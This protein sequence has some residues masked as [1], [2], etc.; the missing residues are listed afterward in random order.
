MSPPHHRCALRPSQEFR[1]VTRG[2]RSLSALGAAR[3]NLW[4]SLLRPRPSTPLVAAGGNRVDRR[5]RAVPVQSKVTIPPL[6]R[7]CSRPS[8]L[9]PTSLHCARSIFVTIESCQ[10][11]RSVRTKR[12]CD[13]WTHLLALPSTPL[14]YIRCVPNPVGNRNTSLHCAQSCS[15]CLKLPTPLSS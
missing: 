11:I 9:Q 1:D 7:A 12:H 14:S 5:C 13:S 15:S 6:P 4:W 2:A 10:P 8:R 3:A